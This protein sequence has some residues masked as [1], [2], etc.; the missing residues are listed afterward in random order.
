MKPAKILF[1]IN[2]V[3]PTKADYEAATKLGNNANVLFRNAQHVPKEAHALERCD[4]VAGEVPE[5]YENAFPSAE[6]AIKKNKA[7]FKKL[8]DSIDDIKPPEKTELTPEA[9]KALE[10]EIAK[11][12]FEASQNGNNSGGTKAPAWQ[13]N[14][15]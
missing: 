6:E 10:D 14:K 4:G 12:K 8:T 11:K 9:K 13:A 3:L 2:G 15:E 1:F 7:D 5:I